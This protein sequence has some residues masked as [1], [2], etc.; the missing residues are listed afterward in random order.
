MA[1]ARAGRDVV[2]PD[3]AARQGILWSIAWLV[4]S[5]TLGLLLQLRL[6]FPDLAASVAPLSAGRLWAAADTTFVFGWLTV[7]GFA[8]A[9]V[10]VPR[11]AMAQLH[12]EVLG[13]AAVVFWSMNLV[14][15]TGTLLGGMNQGRPL[16]ELPGGV[17]VA[18]VVMMLLVSYNVGTTAIRR[19]ER[20]LY[21]SSWFLLAAVVLLPVVF[22][23][24][25]LPVFTGVSDAIVSGFYVNALE[26]YWLAAVGL[27]VA[28]YVVP[29]ETGNPLRSVAL[30]RISFWTLMF[31]GGWAGGRFLLKGPVPDYVQAVAVGM[32]VVLLLPVLSAASTLF[33]TG[34]SR[35]GLGGQAFGLRWVGVGLVSLVL[36]TVL[37]AVSAVPQVSALVGLTEWGAGLRQLA[38]WG[39]FT[40]LAFGLIYRTYP[41]TVGRTWRSRSLASFH[42]WATLSGVAVG[43]GVLL[44]QGIVQGMTTRAWTTI[45]GGDDPISGLW[46]VLAGAQRGF[47]VVAVAAAALVAVAQYVFAWN[48]YRTA[49]QG[50]LVEVLAPSAPV[51]VGSGT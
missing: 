10:I 36:W 1:D 20:T 45:T 9:F 29:V 40:S 49:T 12:N 43:V 25:N 27:G 21:A 22:V 48:A 8:A 14:L 11:L 15:G 47:Q 38:L 35:W 41:L 16:A 13:A 37:L 50:P 4:V 5:A 28:F 33:A 23:V 2:E 19:R 26:W 18:M 42:F 51:A 6:L 46:Q 3:F 34:G 30:A 44:V 7:A 32:T 39:A 31:A 17:D 24:G